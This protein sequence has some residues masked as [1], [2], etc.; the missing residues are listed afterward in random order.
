MWRFVKGFLSGALIGV[1]VGFAL[2]IFAFPYMFPPP[3]AQESLSREETGAQVAKGTFI[4]ANPNDPVHYG[5]GAVSVFPST[6]FLG[7]D[8]EVG[9]GPDF[10][11]YLVPKA[12]IR[13][14]S[15]VKNTMFVDLGRLRAFKGSQNYAIPAGVDLKNFPS[16]VIWCQQFG[17]LI[18]PADLTFE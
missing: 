2:G 12:E 7:E 5:K 3:E 18:S 10:H 8:F 11:V 1:I 14:S 15:E 17:V 4:H 6:V 16:V 13:D 9:P